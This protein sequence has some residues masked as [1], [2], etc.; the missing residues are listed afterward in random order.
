[1]VKHTSSL[2]KKLKTSSDKMCFLKNTAEGEYPFIFNITTFVF[3]NTDFLFPKEPPPNT[4][5][6]SLNEDFQTLSH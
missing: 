1:M 6:L 2:Q 4:E 5:S 3:T